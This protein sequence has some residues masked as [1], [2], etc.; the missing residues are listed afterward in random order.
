[1]MVILLLLLNAWRFEMIPEASQDIVL[2]VHADT[3]IAVVYHQDSVVY[4][5]QRVIAGDSVVWQTEIIDTTPINSFMMIRN[6]TH[7]QQGEAHVLYHVWGDYPYWYDCIHACRDTHGIWHYSL[8]DSM[9]WGT[10]IVVDHAYNPHVMY[11]T[12]ELWHGYR[13]G[14]EWQKEYIDD[15]LYGGYI[16]LECD[17]YDRLYFGMGAPV[18][19]SR[20]G[21]VLFG[22][23][24]TSGWLVDLLQYDVRWA[25]GLTVTASAVPYLCFSEYAGQTWLLYKSDT[26][27][28]PEDVSSRNVYAQTLTTR[29][30]D[31]YVLGE[32]ND[33]IFIWLR[34]TTGW[35]RSV[36]RE[37][38][39]PRQLIAGQNDYIHCLITDNDTVYYGTTMPQACLEYRAEILTTSTPRLST[40]PYHLS[41][42]GYDSPCTIGI[43][44]ITGRMI[45][46]YL[47]VDLND[48]CWSGYDCNNR[49]I[50]TGVYFFII[51][52]PHGEMVI[53]VLIIR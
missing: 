41:F 32:E 6:F 52:H 16:S 43:M 19:D 15:G 10:D 46:R 48:F 27:W 9:V 26:T 47:N 14:D 13:S 17:A 18:C 50:S 36:V 34:S 12:Q 20:Q 25:L 22:V 45:N 23:R 53:P 4:Y 51:Q 21:Y 35:S 1:M 39:Y 11:Y 3:C 40:L 5:A 31:I 7:N 49:M 29:E 8:V 28:Y 2:S 38:G 44:D 33:T 24:D 42:Y 37:S 30:D